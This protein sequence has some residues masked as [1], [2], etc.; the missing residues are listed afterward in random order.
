VLGDGRVQHELRVGDD[1]IFSRCKGHLPDKACGVV[2]V[3]SLWLAV[4]ADL[5]EADDAPSLAG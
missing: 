2:A 5:A 3:A 1:K 4:N